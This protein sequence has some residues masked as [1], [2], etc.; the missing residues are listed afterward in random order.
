MS[1]LRWL[2]AVLR[3]LATSLPRLS[4]RSLLLLV[5]AVSRAIKHFGSDTSGA[6]E[7]ACDESLG[8]NL[9][10]SDFSTA[11]GTRIH[12]GHVS[13]SLA[14]PSL[15]PYGPSAS[16]SSQDIGTLPSHET[17]LLR[18]LSPQDPRP[19]SRCPSPIWGPREEFI[20]PRSP[21]VPDITLSSAKSMHSDEVVTMI[22]QFLGEA[23]SDIKIITGT[24]ETVMRGRYNKGIFIKAP[25]QYTISAFTTSLMP[26]ELPE[27][28]TACT[29]AEGAQ[30]FC[31]DEKQIFTDSNILDSEILGVITKVMRTIEDF[32]QACGIVLDAGVYLVLDA[33]CPLEQECKYYFVNTQTRWIF[34]M[35]DVESKMF[36]VTHEL[37]GTTSASSMHTRHEFGSQYWLHCYLFPSTSALNQETIDEFRDLVLVSLEDRIVSPTSTVPWTIEQ[38]NYMINLADGFR[39]V[40]SQST[41]SSASLSRLMYLFVRERIYN[42]H[43]ETCVRLDSNQCVY[44][45]STTQKPTIFFTLLNP[46]LFYKPDSYLVGLNTIFTDGLIRYQSWPDFILWLCTEWQELTH[47]GIFVLNANV[48][49]LS[50]NS[51]DQ[52]GN[53]VVDRSP[54]QISSYLSILTSL[55]GIIVALL[56]VQQT[57]HQD[58]NNNSM[59]SFGADLI[60]SQTRGLQRLA[61]L[62]SLPYVLFIYSMLL[63]LVAFSFACFQ[64]SSLVT[65]TLLALL[66]TTL[67]AFIL[68]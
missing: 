12:L 59:C 36:P 30:Y 43:G 27:G 63:F 14:P 47:Y 15:F 48:S 58:R 65:H 11:H 41:N 33:S 17:Y 5:S 55:G 8:A 54:A 37:S 61:I 53:L 13:T 57:R 2:L 44:E 26:L 18:S 3:K 1:A 21:R 49:F 60:S 4:I 35:D 68:C 31:H 23:D 16:R 10:P 67:A 29:H 32:V 34:W 50:I 20:T 66:L 7:D 25:T 38:L 62:Y 9:S 6:T 19:R 42:F 40:G 28:W 56:L 24:P 46:L 51:V 45:C 39:L 64:H 22:P 52:N